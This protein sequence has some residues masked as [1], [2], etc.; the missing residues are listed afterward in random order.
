MTH[1]IKQSLVELQN[2]PL[3]VPYTMKKLLE[4]KPSPELDEWIGIAVMGYEHTDLRRVHTEDGMVRMSRYK[5]G[6][7]QVLMPAFSTDLLAAMEV[8][9]HLRKIGWQVYIECLSYEMV[10][11]RM[12]HKSEFGMREVIAER[13]FPRSYTIPEA[14]CKACVQ[15]FCRY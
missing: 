14:I 13:T 9:E 1:E 6:D 5:K 3:Q 2:E 11:C 8:V 15:A 7:R 4:M 12:K 10:R